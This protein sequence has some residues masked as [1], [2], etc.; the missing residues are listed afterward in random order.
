MSFPQPIENFYDPTTN[1]SDL[2][3]GIHIPLEA[4]QYIFCPFCGER[5]GHS[6]MMNLSENEEPIK[7]HYY[8]SSVRT[9]SWRRVSTGYIEHSADISLTCKKCNCE[10]D[11]EIKRKENYKKNRAEY[12]FLFGGLGRMNFN[13]EQYLF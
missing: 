8:P 3:N 13:K 7:D 11:I 6:Q 10:L 1:H 9:F 12:W 2:I 4:Y 5:N